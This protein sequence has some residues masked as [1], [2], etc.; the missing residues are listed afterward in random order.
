MT[1]TLQDFI[2]DY[3][4]WLQGVEESSIFGPGYGSCTC[5]RYWCAYYNIRR[6]MHRELKQMFIED[7]LNPSYPFNQNSQGYWDEVK[8]YLVCDNPK[9]IAWY[10]S[11]AK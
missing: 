2:N 9:R 6:D 8:R 1:K 5:L 11:H 3:D 4:R 7:G 10:R